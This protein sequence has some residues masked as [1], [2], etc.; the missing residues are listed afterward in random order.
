MRRCL[1]VVFFS[2]FSSGGHF[3]QPSRTF[4]LAIVVKGHKRNAGCGEDVFQR[5]F[6]FS[7][8]SSGR[9]LVQPSGA[10]LPNLVEGH[11][12]NTSVQIHVF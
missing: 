1:K 11:W 3:V 12:W 8:F 6:F 7:S 5:F 4:F 2:I 9:H 10:I